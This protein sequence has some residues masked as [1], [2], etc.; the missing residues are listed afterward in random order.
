MIYNIV[1]VIHIIIASVIIGLVLLQHGKGADAGA[2][3]GSGASATVFGSRGSGSFLTRATGVLAALFFMT[4]LGLGYMA[5]TAHEVKSVTELVAPAEP[6]SDL[7]PSVP[8]TSGSVPP[9]AEK[10]APTVADEAPAKG[11]AN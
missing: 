1:I 2:A 6:V 8:T 10:D 11:Q 3:F 7:P 9:A 4:S 5:S